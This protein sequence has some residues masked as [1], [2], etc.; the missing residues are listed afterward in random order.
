MSSPAGVDGEKERDVAEVEDVVGMVQ[1][2]QVGDGEQE[3]QSAG[4]RVAQLRPHRQQA[5]P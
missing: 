3:E 2:H 4:G 1:H 5:L